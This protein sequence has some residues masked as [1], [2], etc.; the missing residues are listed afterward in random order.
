RTL[1]DDLPN[2]LKGADPLPTQNIEKARAAAKLALH[3]LFDE[4]VIFNIKDDR[5]PLARQGGGPAIANPA[6]SPEAGFDAGLD[7]VFPTGTVLGIPIIQT[8][9]GFVDGSALGDAVVNNL[10]T[11]F[12]TLAYFYR[13]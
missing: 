4:V 9:R 6:N 7:F 10:G 11:I 12:T 3:Y 1:V 13:V 5:S 2:A 8:R